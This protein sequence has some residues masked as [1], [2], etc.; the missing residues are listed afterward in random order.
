MAVVFVL[1][2]IALL[3][4]LLLLLVLRCGEEEYDDVEPENE[5]ASGGGRLAVRMGDQPAE[6]APKI[7][8]VLASGEASCR[9]S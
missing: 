9:L 6:E 3:L 1:G 2:V 8:A 7:A 5:K 4:L